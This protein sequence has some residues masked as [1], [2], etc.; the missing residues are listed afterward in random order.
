MEFG[1]VSLWQAI[2]IAA[3]VW[4]FIHPFTCKKVTREQRFNWFCC[5]LFLGFLGYG[6]YY[7]LR[8]LLKPKKEPFTWSSNPDQWMRHQS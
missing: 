5:S 3:I 4:P 1:G 7:V 2:I 8:V 6:L